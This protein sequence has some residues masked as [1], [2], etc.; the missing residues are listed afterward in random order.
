MFGVIVKIKGKE[1]LMGNIIEKTEKSASLVIGKNISKS[2]LTDREIE[3]L[4]LICKGL[5][6]VEI[7]A[8]LFVSPRTV[9]AH[10]A[11]LIAK[12]E[13]NNTADLVMYAVRNHLVEL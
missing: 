3:V 13:A 2:I 5:S 6:S 4:V 11:S 8:Q 1:C 9:E 12:T 10:R 7:G